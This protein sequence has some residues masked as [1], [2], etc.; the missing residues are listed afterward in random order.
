[1]SRREEVFG[2][3]LAGREIPVLTLD[4]KWHKLF[5]QSKP[6]KTITH[7][8]TELNNLIK[9]QG[10]ANTER[11][12]IRKLKKKLMQE[13]MNNAEGASVKDDETAKKKAKELKRLTE[14]CSQRQQECE[15]E[16]LSLPG[17]IERVNRELMLATMDNCYRRLWQNKR[18]IDESAEWIEKTRIELKERLGRN[19]ELEQVNQELYAYMHDIFGAEVID[20]FDMEYQK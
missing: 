6:D 10:K 16:L 3:A 1:M 15:K 7:L 8:Q 11:K 18:E 9:R 4:N 17:E 14:E 20:I 12:E 13:I 5:A 19:Q 2:P